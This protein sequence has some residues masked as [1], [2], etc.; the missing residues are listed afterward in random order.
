MQVHFA[1]SRPPLSFYGTSQS[2]PRCVLQPCVHFEMLG[3]DYVIDEVR[4]LTNAAPKLDPQA[5]TADAVTQSSEND[6][7]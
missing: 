6:G 2:G 7:V 5:C 4:L 1:S 3:A